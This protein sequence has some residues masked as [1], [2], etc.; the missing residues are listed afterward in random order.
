MNDQQ[1]PSKSLDISYSANAAVAMVFLLLGY[2]AYLGLTNS[3]LGA[4]NHFLIICL[5]ALAIAIIYVGIQIGRL[6]EKL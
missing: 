2:A 4:E 1:N 6:V 5:M 3:H